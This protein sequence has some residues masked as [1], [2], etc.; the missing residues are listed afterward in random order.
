ML[1][2]PKGKAV[3]K[4]GNRTQGEKRGW[5]AMG[6]ECTL[7][8]IGKGGPV[9]RTNPRVQSD[10]LGAHLRLSPLPMPNTIAA[11]DPLRALMGALEPS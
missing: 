6:V 2:G 7:T 9:D 11:T 5:G 3:E 10:T 8:V 1:A 4:V